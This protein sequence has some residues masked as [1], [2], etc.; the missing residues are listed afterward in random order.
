MDPMTTS[1][2]AVSFFVRKRS[3][4]LWCKFSGN[5]NG[6][7]LPGISVCI[8]SKHSQLPPTQ[9]HR[10]LWGPTAQHPRQ[11]VW[12]KTGA[13]LSARTPWDQSPDIST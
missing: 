2:F 12:I 8:A 9:A 13:S 5:E 3:S 10:Q 11:G 6:H 4:V 1:N 7:I